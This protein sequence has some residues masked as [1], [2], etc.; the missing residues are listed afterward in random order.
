MTGIDGREL[1][2]QVNAANQAG[3]GSHGLMVVV[4][5]PLGDF[6]VTEVAYEEDLAGALV[7]RTGP[8]L[9]RDEADPAEGQDWADVV[10]R[11]IEAKRR[12]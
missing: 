4:S 11:S 9:P 8:R 1:V 2:R 3:G 12:R 6:H 7:I 10:H 5:T